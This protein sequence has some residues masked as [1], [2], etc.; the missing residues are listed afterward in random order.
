MQLGL[1]SADVIAG[2]YLQMFQPTWSII[3]SSDP[4]DVLT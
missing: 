4:D 3:N 2:F 1:S